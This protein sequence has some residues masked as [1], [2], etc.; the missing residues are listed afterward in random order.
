MANTLRIAMAQLNLLVGDIEGNTNRLIAIAEQARDELQ[1]DVVVF[2]ELSLTGY[3]PEDLLL[4]QGLHRRVL[5]ALETIKRHVY[6]IDMVIGYPHEAIGGLYNAASIVR[7]GKL[8]CTYHK[9]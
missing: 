2:P 4:R 5:A 3:P 6:G 7:D 1:A 9:Q 8:L